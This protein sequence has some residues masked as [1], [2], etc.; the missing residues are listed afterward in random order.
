MESE[1]SDLALRQV[2]EP[3]TSLVGVSIRQIN[4]IKRLDYDVR[5]LRQF[6][7]SRGY[8]D[9]NVER[10]RWASTGWSGFAVALPLMRSIITGDIAFVEI[11]NLIFLFF[12]TLFQLGHEE[13]YELMP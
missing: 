8:A 7:L 12:V 2:I 9:I 6:Y 10:P 13:W 3:E 11:D 5:L 4:M 1:L